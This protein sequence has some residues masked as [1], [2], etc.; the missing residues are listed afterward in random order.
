MQNIKNNPIYNIT[1]EYEF[2]KVTGKF[3]DYEFK[4]LRD[5]NDDGQTNIWIYRNHEELFRDTIFTSNI[6]EGIQY[7]ARSIKLD[8]GERIRLSK[9]EREVIESYENYEYKKLKKLIQE[10][11]Y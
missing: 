7:I 11:E 8:M 9:K 5:P 6:N 4:L 3:L 10:G 2:E 1:N